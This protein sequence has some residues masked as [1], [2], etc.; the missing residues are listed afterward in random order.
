VI[1]SLRDR[2]EELEKAAVYLHH[3]QLQSVNGCL[4][5]S[6]P[7]N[8]LSSILPLTLLHPEE[9]RIDPPGTQ[10]DLQNGHGSTDTALTVQEDILYDNFA[11]ESVSSNGPQTAIHTRSISRCIEPCSFERLMKPIDQAIGESGTSSSA[12]SISVLALNQTSSPNSSIARPVVANTC[13]CDHL[14]EGMRCHLPVRRLADKLITIYF[15]RHNRM[16]PVIHQK[17]F[18]RQDARL[19][20][21]SMHDDRNHQ[22]LDDCASFCRKKSHGKLFAATVSAVFALAA[23]FMTRSPEQ[24]ALQAQQFIRHAKEIDLFEALNGEVGIE[25]VQLGLLV[26][27]YLQST[28]RFSKCFS[29]AGL[30]IRM[31]QNMGLH[32]DTDEARRR[33]LMSTPLTQLDRELR[34]RIWHACVL[35]D[36]YVILSF[37]F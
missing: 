18:L 9:T 28:E 13:I 35:L 15:Q 21:S 6:M 27:F 37:P 2:L 10:S 8:K 20:E 4:P 11:G 33:G 31:A 30:T 29:V 1:Q 7:E 17:T 32:F 26:S 19:W 36:T 3:R 5:A 14:L 12:M 23:L 24:N 16:F 34:S 25:L 22:A